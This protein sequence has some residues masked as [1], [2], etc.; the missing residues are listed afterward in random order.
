MSTD[1]TL[2]HLPPE[3]TK[4]MAQ[5]YPLPVSEGILAGMQTPASVSVRLNPAKKVDK[6]GVLSA[7]IDA[8]VP[9][10]NGLKQQTGPCEP[11]DGGTSVAS[12]YYL[13]ERPRFAHDPFW[14]AG[15]YYVQDASAMFLA[16]VISRLDLFGSKFPQD[17]NGSHSDCEPF[18]A[19]DL[20]AAPGGKSLLLRDLLPPRTI[21]LSNEIHPARAQVLKEN[22]TK[23]CGMRECVVTRSDPR[24]LAQALPPESL[25]LILVDAPCSGEGLFRK[26]PQA[27]EMWSEEGVTMCARRQWD[28]LQQ[29]DRL[30]APNGLLIYCT[31]TLNREENEDIAHR[32]IEALG[33]T[34]VPIPITAQERALG[35]YAPTEAGEQEP[36][37]GVHLF[38]GVVRGEGQ[39]IVVLRK[40]GARA[41]ENPF[42]K[43]G[44]SA[45]S[46]DDLN[47]EAPA[48]LSSSA[49]RGNKKG[50]KQ[51]GESS[52]ALFPSDLK[53]LIPAHIPPEELFLNSD[54]VWCR[55]TLPARR[56][57]SLL[58]QNGVKVLASGT[59][60]LAP[61]PKG[62]R[63][64]A[65]EWSMAMA[66]ASE[67]IPYP[68]VHLTRAEALRY[69][70]GE[71]SAVPEELS[72]CPSPYVLICYQSLPLGFSRLLP[73]RLNNLY[74][75][76]YRLRT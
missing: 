3:F 59:P 18:V 55:L 14:H 54:G 9:W 61:Q 52:E 35:V 30:L 38:P 10:W 47:G 44:K 69:L 67:L 19:L 41:E 7:E 33:Y 23:W 57:A 24:A 63:A 34:P 64:A 42:L 11:S 56:I 20:C 26:E 40:G 70:R 31:C 71:A 28:I 16:R 1:T 48:C 22:L 62:N 13:K 2:L 51:R 58:T 46:S 29:A 72:A 32:L 39:Y 17:H 12:A 21:L 36:S 8:A 65:P 68:K 66:F 49:K 53:G 75:K 45:F 74:P 50:K 27:V 37:L 60:L 76:E 25:D 15:A 5:D 6:D 73:N 4:R 43:P